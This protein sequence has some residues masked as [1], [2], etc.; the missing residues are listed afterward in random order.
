MNTRREIRAIAAA[1][2]LTTVLLAA[3]AHAQHQ[4]Q[5]QPPA[6]AVSPP[7]ETAKPDAAVAELVRRAGAAVQELAAHLAMVRYQEHISQNKLRA[8]NKVEYEQEAYYDS[9]LLV[10]NKNGRMSAEEMLEEEKAPG[11]FE[12]RPLLLTRG[13]ATMAMILHPYYAQSFHFVAEGEETEGGRRLARLHFEHIK[14][15]DSP[16][17]LRLRGRTY[18]LGMAGTV[19]IDEESGAVARVHGELS[20]SMEDIGLHRLDCDVRYALVK[21]EQSADQ[22]WL[23]V[24]A[25][26]D[27]ETPKQHWRNIH[28]YTKYRKFE[29]KA[30]LGS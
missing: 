29:V 21:M 24:L 26:V 4:T 8:N 16:T 18:P 23:P 22:Y 12:Q 6:Q 9:L 15:A 30:K 1:S 17:V 11:H 7:G 2:L 13:F 25:T 20:E 10:H 19:W 3:T 27:L 28:E 5:S 14:G